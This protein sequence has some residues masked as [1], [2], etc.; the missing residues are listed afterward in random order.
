MIS[1]LPSLLLVRPMWNLICHKCLDHRCVFDT[2]LSMSHLESLTRNKTQ[3]L[4][5]SMLETTVHS[6]G[7]PTA[8][9]NGDLILY[10]L[11]FSIHTKITFSKLVHLLFWLFPLFYFELC[12]WELTLNQLILNMERYMSEITEGSLN[13]LVK[14]SLHSLTDTHMAEEPNYKEC[15]YRN[16]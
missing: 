10:T 5:Q 4:T 16:C 15:F 11:V 14:H 2:S 7:L 9:Y 12:S 13:E 3:I 8:G 6:I 1:S